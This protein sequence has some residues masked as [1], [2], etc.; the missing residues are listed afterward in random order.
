[1]NEGGGDALNDRRRTSYSLARSR[2]FL[3]RT[4]PS[5][6]H[7]RGPSHV[8]DERNL[9][10]ITILGQR[11]NVHV[12]QEHLALA[13]LDEEHVCATLA[14]GNN[15]VFR[16]EHLA[17]QAHY[18]PMNHVRRE[19][20]E[21][22][23]VDQHL[24]VRA[25][26]NLD[27]QVGAQLLHEVVHGGSAVQAVV[28]RPDEIVELRGG[29]ASYICTHT[30]KGGGG[31]DK[32]SLHSDQ[33]GLSNALVPHRQFVLRMPRQIRAAITSSTAALCPHVPLASFATRASPA[34]LSPAASPANPCSPSPRTAPSSSP[35]TSGCWS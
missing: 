27:G 28:L 32:C 22:A 1:M 21:E 16:H 3:A 35:D 2:P 4:S 24:L 8:R 6:L 23:H 33:C 7:T 5:H 13:V 12:I 11:P 10:K 26:L 25:H 18:E 29:L 30:H 20:A 14:N 9:A 19:L 15:V 17:L 34:T 31:A